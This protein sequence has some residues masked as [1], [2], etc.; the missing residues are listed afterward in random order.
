MRFLDPY[1]LL[2]AIDK[3]TI[4][5][6]Q[7]KETLAGEH[8]T[9]VSPAQLMQA[10]RQY[11]QIITNTLKV[12][13]SCQICA[14]FQT[15]KTKKIYSASLED[16]RKL[17]EKLAINGM[18]QR[19]GSRNRKAKERVNKELKIID[20]LGFNAYFLITWDI[21][22]YAQ[23]QGFFY[24]GRGSGANSIV[25]YCLLITHFSSPPPLSFIPT[26]LQKL[27]STE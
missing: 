19:Y 17:L 13:D 3:N 24:I 11:P 7:D 1:R 9:F 21:I 8:E 5:S 4:L 15:D 25:A 2:Q 22:R 20:E 12:L 23:S 27:T 26:F 16:D 18:V 10:F 14:D 6:K